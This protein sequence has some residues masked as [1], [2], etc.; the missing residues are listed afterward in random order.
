MSVGNLLRSARSRAGVSAQ[1]LARRAATSRTAI[2]AYEND[3]KTP[4]AD[5]LLRLLRAA[6]TDVLLAPP[7]PTFTRHDIDRGRYVWVP[8]R[9]PRLD[10]A[11]ALRTVKIPRRIFWSSRRDTFDLS[12]PDDRAEVYAAVLSE[13]EPTDIL[14]HVDGTLLAEMWERMWLPPAVRNAWQPL[15]DA[16]RTVRS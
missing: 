14:E 13:G 8:D 2:S 3:R 15:I 7:A 6:G 1:E 11:D 5:T 16:A 10:P 4:T 9:L 12:D